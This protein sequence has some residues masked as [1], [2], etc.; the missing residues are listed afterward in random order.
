VLAAVV[1]A[2]AAIGVRWGTF[3]AGGSDSYC[4][5]HQAVRWA[6]GRLQV[7]DPL[8]LEAPWPDAPLT[9]AP[10]GHRPSSTVPGA[11]V[12]VCPAG[13]S[14][15]MAPFIAV[16]GVEAAF[17]VV[18]LFG[19]CLI[20]ATYRAG[21][22]YG[23]RIGLAAAVVT[24]A[25][26]VFLYQVVQPMSDVP[27]AALW[28]LAVA[29]VTGARSGAV[30]GGMAAGAA[31]VVRPNLV[32]L[33]LPLA[34]FLLR[35]P[36]RSRRERRRDAAA[37][38]VCAGI[39]VACAALI[40]Y[41]FYGSPLGSGYGPLETLFSLDHVAPNAARYASWLTSA[42]TPAWLMAAAAPALLPGALTRLLTGM[43]LLNAALYLP[44]VVFGDWSYLRFLLPTLPLLLVLLVASLD[45]VCRRIAP[46]T[47][48][49]VVGVAAVGLAVA[50]IGE[51]QARQAFHLHAL[52]ARYARAGTFV[53]DRLPPNAIV[54]T[55][56]HSGSVR[57]YSGRPTLVWDGLD[58]AWLDRALGYLRARGLEPV[59]LFESWEEPLFR[60][61]FRAS[62]LGALD[63]PPA[64]EIASRVRVYRP[65][66]RE[67]YLQGVER[68]TEYVP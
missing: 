68:P 1:A 49:A 45:A 42:Q 50:G 39:G 40:Q 28:M 5:V 44:Y 43:L 33:A 65:G 54:V 29:A 55:S 8:A 20:A 47:A 2:V 23:V 62:P 56:W 4:Y 22:R 31:V 11:I 58:P 51:A 10:A 61:R 6:S 30:S 37:F 25:S 64:A 27:A 66:D 26:P 57:H 15:A 35:R 3:V 19:A 41:S 17:L 9:F 18:P 38:A 24:A 21:A 14:I 7:P 52:E 34:L 60:Q 59:L 46:W 36:E 53:A 67:A 48:P 63:W 16:G 12:P 32:P 13:L